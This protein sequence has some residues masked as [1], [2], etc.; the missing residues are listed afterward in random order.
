MTTTYSEIGTLLR[1]A[2]LEMRIGIEDAAQS[3]H[4]R[5]RYL[6][7]LEQG[8]MDVLPG[9]AY[10]KGY[11]LSY[12]AFLRLDRDE[13]VRRFEQ[14]ESGIEQ[15]A[16]F[17]PQVLR[18][19]KSPPKPVV[20]GGLAVAFVAYL[21]WALALRS[22]YSSI[23]VVDAPPGSTPVSAAMVDNVACL[24]APDVLYPPCHYPGVK[25]AEFTL[26]PLQGQVRTIMDLK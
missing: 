1:A 9:L 25:K 2:R 8:E 14:V 10:A 4:I 22:Q 12:A 20:M 17:M 18:R 6:E 23:S 7:A 26:V 16:F 15:R 13:I 5:V 21:V 11:L 19:E 3:L 24:R